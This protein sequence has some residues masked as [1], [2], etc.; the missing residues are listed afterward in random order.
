VHA[1]LRFAD[2]VLRRDADVRTAARFQVSH[3]RPGAVPVL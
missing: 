1:E 3:G 2:S